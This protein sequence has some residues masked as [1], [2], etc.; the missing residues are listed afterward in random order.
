MR[1]DGTL[2]R[3]LLLTAASCAHAAPSTLTVNDPGDGGDGTCT[4]TCT[5]RDAISNIAYGGTIDIAPVLL[6][7][8]ITL[9]KGP[10]VIEKSLRIQG[11]GATQLAIS[12]NAL[13]R[14]LVVSTISGGA[15]DIVGVTVRDGSV[16][17][18]NGPSGVA[19]SGDD[20]QTGSSPLG[21][22][23]EVVGG[24]L[25]LDSVDIRNCVAQ[26]GNGGDGGSGVAGIGLAAGG[27][28]GKGGPGG[29]GLGGGILFAGTGNLTLRNSS[30][31]NGQALGGAGGAGGDGGSGFFR[32][33]GGVG[34]TGGYAIGG[35]ILMESGGLLSVYN[36]TI[37][38]SVAIAGPAGNGGSGDNTNA[39]N[40]GGDGGTGGTALAGLVNVTSPSVADLEFATLANGNVMAGSPG[41]GGSGQVGG[42]AGQAGA[43]H[44]IAI[45]TNSETTALSSV[46]VG[47]GSASLCFGN[48]TS[49]VGSANLDEDSSCSG[50]TLHA[51]FAQLF[52]SLD[53]S[54]PR[55]GYV[56]VYQSAVIDAGASCNDLSTQAVTADQHGTPRPQGS[57]CDLGAIE[58]DYIFV[59]GLD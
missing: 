30:L 55:P 42:A 40:P 10:L 16:S 13:S 37:A 19:A 5:L 9:T 6:P 52:R 38:G 4:S 34:G 59:D 53:P 1:F 44:G 56:P 7:V 31:I 35:A 50:F 57:D 48:V 21:G 17:G 33:A 27:T 43:S 11:S 28:G 41:E 45:W 22:C 3:V 36:S 24:S 12:A 23:I 39:L 47:A 49:A 32:G 58:A 54:T 20:G 15:V 8:T 26:G 14:V 51:T 18:T 2:V 29:A 25:V 46:I